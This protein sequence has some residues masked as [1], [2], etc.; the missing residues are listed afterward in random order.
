MA[1][2]HQMPP[3]P[4]EA[5]PYDAPVYATDGVDARHERLLVRVPHQVK[6]PGFTLLRHGLYP[7]LRRLDGNR[8]VILVARQGWW[9]PAWMEPKN[10]P[11]GPY[12]LV[13]SPGSYDALLPMRE[14]RREGVGGDGFD[15]L[16]AI[17]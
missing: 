3:R 17:Q 10:P 5:D 9:G 15:Y 11:P 14:E 12:K 2:I 8:L 13:V 1:V 4:A 7:L 16:A 6:L